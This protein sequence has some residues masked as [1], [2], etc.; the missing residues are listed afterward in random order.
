LL[1]PFH[2]TCSKTAIYQSSADEYDDLLF[3]RNPDMNVFLTG[4]A[5]Y[6][7][8][9]VAR[10]LLAS[11]HRVRGLVRTPERAVQV[12][13]QGI[14]P[15]LGN[16][17]DLSLLRANASEADAVVS[18]A[19]ADDRAS[20]E[21]MLA[22]LV[23]SGK[24]FV[25]TSGSGVIADCAGG[26][27][28]DKIYEDVSPIDPKPLRAARAAL[29][30]DIIAAARQGVRS[31]VVAPPM[32]YGR[33]LGVHAHSIQVPAMIAHARKVGQAQFIGAGANRW[34]N[35]HIEDLAD[36]YR[37]ALEQAPAGLYCYAENGE[38]SMREIADA[39]SR[40][41][42]FRPAASITIAEA[43][44]AFGE[45]PA[46]YSFGSNSRVR[47]LKARDLLGWQPSARALVDEI[48]NGC[49]ATTR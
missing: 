30:K 26:A 25:H 39:I 31:V 29:N 7:G 5:G 44:A 47:A 32:I 38:N 41:F 24:V 34:S 3:Q 28:T 15:V 9:S 19:N 22:G 37:M 35:V 12:R 18:A 6:V 43:S 1:N 27:A 16:L 21:A 13:S 48:E 42:G 20:V 4:A 36:L 17:S 14:E 23:G 49:Y 40:T 2:E 46:N 45:N 33:G 10:K 8:G 11:G